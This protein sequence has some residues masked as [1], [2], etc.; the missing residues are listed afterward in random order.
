M[1]IADAAI[2][3]LDT[4]HRQWMDQCF[5]RFYQDLRNLTIACAS[6]GTAPDYATVPLSDHAE[7][8]PKTAVEHLM[9]DLRSQAIGVLWRRHKVVYALDEDFWT[10]LL[11]T[12][13]NS[14]VP[15]STFAR[16]PHDN[17][18]IAFPQP[19]TVP[20]RDGHIE[21]TGCFVAGWRDARFEDQAREIPCRT[22]HPG[23]Q[24][25]LLLL[26]QEYGSGKPVRMSYTTRLSFDDGATL[27]EIIATH[28]RDFTG[29]DPEGMILGVTVAV[30]TLVY[31]C[32]SNADIQNAA[33][34]PTRKKRGRK[35]KPTRVVETGFRIGN[36]I[37][38]GRI[39]RTAESTPGGG[40][41]APH[42]RRAHFHTYR[43]GPGRQ[44]SELKWLAPIPVKLDGEAPLPTVV[45]VPQ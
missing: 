43:V 5:S 26:G 31:V 37:R 36:A 10:E 32:A 1:N 11:A 30:L 21:L 15:L 22:T 35:E 23:S 40:T 3:T 9:S 20:T 25:E 4:A 14:P 39:R 38:A 41:V 18:F 12:D 34:A 44:E 28:R 7:C 42:L 8:V 45:P 33:V 19:L 13:L 24:P 16:L 6:D 27:G 2:E 29:R 17:P